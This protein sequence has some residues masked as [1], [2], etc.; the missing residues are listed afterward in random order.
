MPPEQSV[1]RCNRLDRHETTNGFRVRGSRVHRVRN[2]ASSIWL[3]VMHLTLRAPVD[4]LAPSWRRAGLMPVQQAGVKL[5][6]GH[7][8][9]AHAAEHV[10]GGQRTVVVT[11][12]SVLVIGELRQGIEGL[13]DRWLHEL[14]QRHEARVLPV[15]AAVA[16]RWG[17]LNV[18]DPVLRWM[19]C[20]QRPPLVHSLTLVTRNVRDVR[21]AP[22]CG[23][24]IRSCDRP[25]RPRARPRR[26]S[27]RRR[28]RRCRCGPH[29]GTA[30]NRRAAR[31]RG[32]SSASG[33]ARARSR[34]RPRARWRRSTTP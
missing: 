20:S 17:R 24:S 13:L 10:F 25:L 1:G 14:V 9:F 21:R 23:T 3:F 8:A 18:P 19:G 4:V 31:R 32:R 30:R 7:S 34:P 16:E 2:P 11:Y 12:L 5:P 29:R 6:R 22:A 33:P 27:R 28:A 26:T 15:D